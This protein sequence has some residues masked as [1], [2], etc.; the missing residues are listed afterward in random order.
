MSG[1]L[2]DVNVLLALAWPNH[3]FHT[4]AR[5]WFGERRG[6]WYTC[7]VTQLGFVRLSSNLAF[8]R[9]AK[10]PL[11]ASLL[12]RSMACHPDHHFVAESGPLTGQPFE[13]VAPRLHGHQQ[14]TDAYLLTLAQGHGLR[15]VTF[16]RRLD[17]ISRFEGLVRLL[18]P[19][20][21]A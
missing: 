20:R 12:L 1:E 2:P 17:V 11:E 13:S 5:G 9:H 7:A 3:Q 10:T 21:G 19:D 16:D 15:L 6:P 8:T 18:P 4:Q 14:V